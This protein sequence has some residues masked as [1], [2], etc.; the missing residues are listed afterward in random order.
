[1]RRGR[2]WSNAVSVRGSPLRAAGATIALGGVLAV[3]WQRGANSGLVGQVG[4]PFGPEH[5]R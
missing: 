5:R 2:C 3:K 4:D 1:M